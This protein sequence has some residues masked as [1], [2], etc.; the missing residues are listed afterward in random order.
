MATRLYFIVFIIL[1]ACNRQSKYNAV[2]KIAINSSTSKAHIPQKATSTL[3]RDTLK[4]NGEQYILITKENR[5]NCLISINGDTVIPAKNYYFQ[6][7]TLDI[8][9]DGCNDV[10]VYLM[11]EPNYCED[12]LFDKGIKSFRRMHN[13]NPDIK[14]LKGTNLYY[15]YNHVGCGDD[16]WESHLSKIDN[17]TEVNI[18]L[19]DV[20]GCGDKDDG[21][22]IYKT[23]GSNE[24]L[25]KKLPI[26]QFDYNSKNNKWQFLKSYWKNNYK[27][28]EQ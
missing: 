5:F 4:S 7:K 24:T 11:G 28:F 13:K 17:W 9:E 8:N 15:S 2:D 25:I 19:M 18:G 1:A 3:S 16:S 27:L 10:R 22:K 20:H 21:I 14:K 12:Y 6:A 23:V 26:R